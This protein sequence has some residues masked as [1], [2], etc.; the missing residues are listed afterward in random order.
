MKFDF[1]SLEA[2]KPALEIVKAK[3]PL[4]TMPIWLN[5]DI[6]Q[7]PNGRPSTK[8]PAEFLKAVESFPDAILS[9]GWT[10]V[11]KGNN[12]NL[13][14]TMAMVE[15]MDAICHELP[16]PVT[17]PVR[18]EQLRDSW[19]AFDWLLRQSRGYTLTVWTAPQDN[20]TKEDMDFI[21]SQ[22]ELS[23]VYFDLPKKLMP[24]LN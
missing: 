9:L 11:S 2:V 7:G 12:T 10:T 15:E 4:I 6:L 17:F 3:G 14:Y 24:E 20:V 23:R 5:A 18:A 13:N 8:P 21:K 22:A 1:K 16:Q 19:E